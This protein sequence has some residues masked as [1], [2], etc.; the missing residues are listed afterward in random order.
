M[1]DDKDNS[2]LEILI[3]KSEDSQGEGVKVCG[4]IYEAASEVYSSTFSEHRLTEIEGKSV[5]VLQIKVSDMPPDVEHIIVYA[6]GNKYIR[7]L[8]LV[9]VPT[10]DSFMATLSECLDVDSFTAILSEIDDGLLAQINDIVPYDRFVFGWQE[11]AMSG[12]EIKV[13]DIPANVRYLTV[14]SEDL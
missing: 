9:L 13:A 5:R 6:D 7:L 4:K 12:I 10:L 11:R 8:A 3:H 14:W 1:S 2:G